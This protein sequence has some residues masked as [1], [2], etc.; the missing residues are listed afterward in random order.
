MECH[1]FHAIQKSPLFKTR[2]P[3]FS[4][5]WLIECSIYLHFKSKF[6][7]INLIIL[8]DMQRLHEN[9]KEF[10]VF[11]TGGLYFV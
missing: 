10:Y 7:T 8:V 2:E 4:L 9:G 11:L 3:H 6:F 1:Q 5:V